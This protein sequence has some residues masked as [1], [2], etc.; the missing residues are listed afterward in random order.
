MT[1]K[2]KATNLAPGQ[3]WVLRFGNHQLVARGVVGAGG[4]DGEDQGA[5]AAPREVTALA[6]VRD[7][8]AAP[9]EGCLAQGSL[10]AR[11]GGVDE[12][13]EQAGVDGHLGVPLYGDAQPL[14]GC[15]H[16]LQQA[17]V[18]PRGSRRSRGVN[19]P[20]GGGG[21]ARSSDGPS[22]EPSLLSGATDTAVSPKLSPPGLCCSCPT[23]S[24]TCWSRTPPACTAITCI[25]RQTPSTGSPAASAASSSASSQESRSSRQLVVCSCGASPYAEGETSAPPLITRPSSRADAGGR[26]IGVRQGRREQDRDAAGG[27]DRA[28]VDRRQEVGGLVPGPPA[29]LLAVGAET[30]DRATHRLLTGASRR[31][32]RCHRRPG[33][34]RRS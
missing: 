7:V 21:S 14:A 29:S 1:L 27:L 12:G 11:R 16:R 22:I 28:G 26:R 24:G 33:T 2:F 8:R 15:L 5:T 6:D 31:H 23:A 32:R 20:T 4:R 13:L 25:P 19:A 17:V 18:G 3:R 30:D 10:G 9:Q 34:S